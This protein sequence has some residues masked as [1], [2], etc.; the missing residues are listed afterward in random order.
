MFFSE[1]FIIIVVSFSFYVRWREI[2]KSYIISFS[3]Y[4][5]WR[6]LISVRLCSLTNVWTTAIQCQ[7]SLSYSYRIKYVN[8]LLLSNYLRFFL[9]KEFINF[10]LQ[11][12][13][14]NLKIIEFI[15]CMIVINI[16]KLIADQF[17][18]SVIYFHNESMV[19]SCVSDS[20]MFSIVYFGF[21]YI[22]PSY[23]IIFTPA[24]VI[25]I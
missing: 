12:A 10:F 15:S 14:F 20:Y 24:N 21:V 6:E 7:L 22:Y 4:E 17:Y 1:I 19:P 23:F 16:I 5:Q 11:T 8:V 9:L 18:F 2:F 3:A 13:F 25:V